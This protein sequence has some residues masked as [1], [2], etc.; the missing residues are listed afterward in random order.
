MGASYRPVQWPAMRRAL[1]A[2]FLVL[3]AVGGARAQDA[4]LPPDEAEDLVAM[5]NARGE[6]SL[7]QGNYQEARLRFGKALARD[8]RNRTARLGVVAAHRAVGAYDAAENEL[9]A[10]LEADPADREARL[11]QAELD[12]LRGRA[13]AARDAARAVIA[14][15]GEGPDL[16]GLRARAVLA[17]ACAASGLRDQA[18]EALEPVLAMYERRYDAL[19]AALEDA[20]AVRA[21]ARRAR[22]LAAEMTAFARALRLFVEL[23]PLEHEL[24]QN[25]KELLDV[26][27]QRIDPENWEAWVEFVRVTRH[28]REKAI[29]KARTALQHAERR[30]P[31]VADLYVE[32]AKTLRVGFGNELE[33]RQLAEKA[34]VA[35]PGHA[36]ARAIA[37]QVFLEDN[38]YARADDHIRAGLKVNPRHRAL[39]SLDATL[40]LLTG[41]TEGF[42]R[43]MAEVLAIDP[44]FG[45]GFHLAGLVVA[46]RQRRYDRAAALVRRA[47]EID[48]QHFEAH[49]SLGIFLANLGRAEEAR[50]SLEKA[51]KLFPMRHPVRDN[52]ADVLAYVTGTLTSVTTDHFVIRLDP[53]EYDVLSRFLPPLLEECWADMTPRYAFEPKAPVLVEVFHKAD[54]FS[55]RTI[56]LPGIPALGACF[57]GLVTLDSP[58]ALPP[59]QFS[60]ASTARHEFAHVI[61]LQLSEGQV[62]R[63]FTE[64]LSVLEERPLDPGWG[65]NADMER[66]LHDAYHT[67]SLP[68]IASFDAVFRSP[69]VVF[70]YHVAGL[71]LALLEERSGTQG[72]AT[73]L[74]LYGKD[75]PMR[76][77]FREAFDLSPERFDALFRDFVGKRVA[78]Y[79]LV[80][81]YRPVL[82]ALRAKVLEDPGDGETLLKVAWAHFQNG[83][84]VDAAAWLDRAGAR[85][86][87][88][89]L[90]VTLL[91]AQLALRA[92]RPDRAR[93]LF[94]AF[95]E[96]GGED[97]EARLAMARF[98][99]AENDARRYEEALRKAKAAFPC[100]VGQGSPYA[101]LAQFL[102]GRGREDDALREMEEHAR[103]ASTDL[104]LR[105]ALAR[106]YVARDR[107]EDAIRVLL[108]ALRITPF[109][110]ETH[111]ALVPLLR[112]AG[113]LDEALRSAFCFARLLPEE[114]PIEMQVDAWMDLAEIALA[115]GKPEEARAAHAEAKRR[116]GERAFPRLE[117]FEKFREE[118]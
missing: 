53:R 32:V 68:S 56:G 103:V 117:S 13:A 110:A 73:A 105:L 2:P 5:Y 43:G 82:P 28:D 61:S 33:A 16:A 79:R 81:D 60:W 89:H 19:A 90:G 3:L 26:V 55:V 24:L 114:A 58:Q 46:S 6:E 59:G 41:D 93:A 99:A 104:G 7:R 98:H 8:P 109:H 115:A 15:G 102:L 20:A 66:A 100:R 77:V 118:R 10:M 63:W 21:D 80:P 57:G 116:A 72:I 54:D 9:R 35:N 75:R 45:E 88:D 112:E 51:R 30:N 17:E 39:L 36:D 34:L 86:P 74:R 12:L 27:T 92:R 23:S 106:E 64:G 40:K 48:P 85:L 107:A 50:A 94:E 71:M 14:S 49:A 65:M 67:D 83:Q 42:E 87:A 38:E 69:R 37:A 96:K 95:F 78:G 22:P 52:F 70:A 29:A 113:R 4:D 1:P 84:N 11:A 97:H 76:E 25:A 31:E 91:R 47:I 18:R 101:L 108:E 44:T 111:K 62:P